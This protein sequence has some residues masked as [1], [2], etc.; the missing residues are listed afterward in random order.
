M[1]INLG[2]AVPDLGFYAEWRQ[3]IDRLAET[4]QRILA[5]RETYGIHLD[6]IALGGERVQWVLS[7]IH[8]TLRKDD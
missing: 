7:E 6:T 8:E 5:D 4:G 2:I 3:E 1:A